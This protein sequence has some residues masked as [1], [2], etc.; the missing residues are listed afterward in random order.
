MPKRTHPG[1]SKVKDLIPA[2]TFNALLV[3]RGA[4]RKKAGK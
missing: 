4:L 1:T 3:L 2:E